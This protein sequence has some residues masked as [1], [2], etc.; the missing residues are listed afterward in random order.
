[1]DDRPALFAMRSGDIAYDVLASNRWVHEL[2]GEGRPWGWT[3]VF[4]RMVAMIACSIPALAWRI[5]FGARLSGEQ[6]VRRFL[7]W[8]FSVAIWTP[9]GEWRVART[10][11]DLRQ[12]IADGGEIESSE[13]ED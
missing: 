6:K 9:P 5:T 1:M 7:R 8:G 11:T 10:L 3:G 4:L 2:A 13:D 12:I